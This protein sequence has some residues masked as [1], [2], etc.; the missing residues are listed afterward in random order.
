MVP[1]KRQLVPL[2]SNCEH[3][4]IA[5]YLGGD[6]SDIRS[7]VVGDLLVGLGSAVG[8]HQEDL[9]KLNINPENCHIFHRLN[10]FELLDNQ[11]VHE[12][13]LKWLS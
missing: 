12:Q 6:T 7:M 11:V 2:A 5:A 3:Y 1:D 10:H 8:H 4:F 9:G 13:V